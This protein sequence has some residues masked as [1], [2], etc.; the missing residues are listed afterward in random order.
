MF[1]IKLNNLWVISLC[2][3]MQKVFILSIWAYLFIVILLKIIPIRII[4]L[5][6]ITINFIET[7]YWLAV[8]ICVKSIPI[9][10]I[11][12]PYC[13]S[14]WLLLIIVS[15]WWNIRSS[16][17]IDHPWRLRQWLI[18]SHCKWLLHQ[19]RFYLL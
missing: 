6:I 16:W 8:I 12:W 15:S 9:W 2:Y 11:F 5:I 1:L 7:L 13:R 19:W 18:I 17:W 4:L 3:S 10:T 14:T